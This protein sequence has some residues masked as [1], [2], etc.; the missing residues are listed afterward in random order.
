[1]TKRL[2]LLVLVPL[3]PLGQARIEQSLGAPTVQQQVLYLWSGG[4]VKKLFPGFESIAAD[5]YWLRTVQYFGSERR[6]AREKRFDLLRPLIDITTDL[7]PRLEVAYRYG[8]IF[9]AE[10]APEGAGRPREAVEVLEKGVRM[11][12]RS[13]RLRQDLGFFNYIFL[14]DA[15]RASEILTEAAEVPGAPFWLRTLG[16]DLLLKGGER[17]AAR[18]MW[19]QMYEQAEE[20]VIKQNA[21]FRLLSLDSEDAADR[22]TAAVEEYA[23]RF[24]RRPARLEELPQSGLWKGPLKDAGDV[25]FSYD[26]GTGRVTVS[27][28]S[29]MWRPQ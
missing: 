7:D 23:R 16:A 6:F 25:P 28:S 21:R 8:A 4:H 24:G 11:N 3:V 18:T 1:V 13:W 29:P 26:A 20:G 12:P 22:L 10:P 2:A 5:I 19:R 27:Q 17:R 15:Q 9:L 14:H